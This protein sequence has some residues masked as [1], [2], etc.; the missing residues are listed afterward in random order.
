M[1]VPIRFGPGA[2]VEVYEVWSAELGDRNGF[3]EEKVRTVRRTEAW[4]GTYECKE[5]SFQG[6]LLCCY[7]GRC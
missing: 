6:A 3:E 1:R 5:H 4:Q 7:C 2:E